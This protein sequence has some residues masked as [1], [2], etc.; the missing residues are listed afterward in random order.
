MTKYMLPTE[1]QAKKIQSGIAETARLIRKEEAYSKDL[2][3]KDYLA[4][5][6]AHL[7]TL[8]VMLTTGKGLPR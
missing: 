3:K 5:L 7:Q 6:Y 8:N 4:E 1:W 2:Q